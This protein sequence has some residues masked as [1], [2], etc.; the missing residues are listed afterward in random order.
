MITFVRPQ[1]PNLEKLVSRSWKSKK[2]M[3]GQRVFVCFHQLLS[4]LTGKRVL[5]NGGQEKCFSKATMDL[6]W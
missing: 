2:P 4:E 3:K 1:T 6:T 5:K